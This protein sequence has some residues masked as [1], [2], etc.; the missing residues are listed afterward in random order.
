MG[1]LGSF[2]RSVGWIFCYLIYFRVAFYFF[3]MQLQFHRVVCTVH[4]LT[5][6][7]TDKIRRRMSTIGRTHTVM[8]LRF[9][10]E[11][12]WMGRGLL[13]EEQANK[14]AEMDRN[15]PEERAEFRKAAQNMQR[16]FLESLWY[17]L[18]AQTTNIL[19][20]AVPV[21]LAVGLLK[22]H[23]AITFA[24]NCVA[25]I[26]LAG[27]LSFATEE[28]AIPGGEAFG[29]FMNATFGNAVE[30]IVSIFALRKGE[31]RIVQASMLG[32]ILSNLLLVRNTKSRF[33]GV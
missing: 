7:P 12:S 29:G 10:E 31:I 33:L 14:L 4:S 28:V 5:L 27:M 16:S 9:N 15:T 3:F 24:A 23:P 13:T 20:P 22:M 17:V 1:G 21:G 6:P 19:L 25:I 8:E 30:I 2:F 11:T 18:R 26:P 32:S